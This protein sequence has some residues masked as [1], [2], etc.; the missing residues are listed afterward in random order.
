MLTES[1]LLALLAGAAG[2]VVASWSSWLLI[3]LVNRGADT[4]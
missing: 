1:V 2:L 3:A 4:I